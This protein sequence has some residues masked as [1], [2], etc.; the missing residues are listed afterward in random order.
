MIMVYVSNYTLVWNLDN[1][2]SAD[3]WQYI[4]LRFS[5][6]AAENMLFLILK[7]INLWYRKLAVYPASLGFPPSLQPSLTASL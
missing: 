4:R 6:A 1:I 7:M 5:T 2:K 3:V